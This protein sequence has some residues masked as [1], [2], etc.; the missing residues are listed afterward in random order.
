MSKKNAIAIELEV[1]ELLAQHPD[2]ARKAMTNPQL[3]II[4]LENIG[5]DHYTAFAIL[6]KVMETLRAKGA[7]VDPEFI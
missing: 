3:F 2:S 1:G 6:G 5:F 7:D 4:G